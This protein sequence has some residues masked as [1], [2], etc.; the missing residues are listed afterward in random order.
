MF[1]EFKRRKIESKAELS[2][3]TRLVF[4]K[5]NLFSFHAFRFSFESMMQ[6]V[7]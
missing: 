1:E 4:L 7:E 6:N 3:V 2:L 5:L